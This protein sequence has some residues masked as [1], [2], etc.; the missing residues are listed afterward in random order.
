MASAAEAAA[1]DPPPA[2]MSK[3]LHDFLAAEEGEDDDDPAPDS[4][5]D[6][7]DDDD[8][9]GDGMEL[10]EVDISTGGGA[11]LAG[12]EQQLDRL[13]DHPVLRAILDQVAAA[14]RLDAVLRAD[15]GALPSSS[16]CCKP[17]P[18][19]HSDGDHTGSQKVARVCLYQKNEADRR[20]R[21]GLTRDLCCTPKSPQ[22]AHA[23][24]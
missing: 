15:S 11:S 17:S 8:N 5:G 24:P 18:R 2:H 10:G 14:A 21:A 23:S 7:N 19:D 16:L 4:N 22:A 3:A 1:D 6:I 9:A 12:L 13:S 20:R